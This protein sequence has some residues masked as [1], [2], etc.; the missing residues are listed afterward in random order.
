ML[1]VWNFLLAFIWA[2]VLEDFSAANLAIGFVVG[3]LILFRVRA[4]LGGA[5]YFRDV[6]EV[7]E[8]LAFFVKELFIANF[9]MAYYTVMPLNRMR[10]GI[11]AVPLEDLSDTELTILCNVITLTPGTLSLV[12]SDDKRT[13]YIHVMYFEDPEQFRREIKRGFEQKVIRALR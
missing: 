1:L 10:P 5:N 9:R 3:F 13:L 2:A 7:A 4:A 8:F 12:V 11:I 6:R